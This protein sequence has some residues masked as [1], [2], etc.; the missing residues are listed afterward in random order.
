MIGPWILALGLVTPRSLQ[1]VAR[2][3]AEP[4]IVEVALGRLTTATMASFRVGSRVFVPVVEFFD[5]AEIKVIHSTAFA[6]EASIEPAGIPFRADRKVGRLELGRT[7]APL[8]DSNSLSANGMLYL[9]LETLAKTLGLQWNTSWADLT[10]TIVDPAALP[11]GQR[12]TREWRRRTQ[13]ARLPGELIPERILPDDRH[14]IDGLVLDYSAY[15]P[16]TG[17]FATG[18]Y[19]AALGLDVVGGSFT[20]SLESQNPGQ[21]GLRSEAAWAG[22]WRNRKWLTQLRLGD[23]LST[24]PR[25]RTVRGVSFGNSPYLRPNALGD[26]T[27]SGKLGPGWQVEAYRGGRLIG[28]DSVNALGR[29]TID[30]PIAYGENPVELIAYG[31]FGEVR[32]FNRTYRADPN[33]LPNGHLEYGAALGQCRTDRCQATANLDLRYGLSRHWTAQAG[34][35]QFWRP[36]STTNLFHPYF[37]LSGTI[38]N[39]FGVQFDAV[40]NAIVRG[41]L[42]YE[43][44]TSLIL[45]AEV[46]RFARGVAEPILTPEGRT[47]QITLT[48]IYFP[49]DR[50]SSLFIEGSVDRITTQSA[51]VTSGRIGVSYQY[52]QIQFVPSVR[53]QRDRTAGATIKQ[54]ILGLNAYLLPIPELGSLF[55]QATARVNIETSGRL[56]PATLT[57][58]ISRNLR[59][60]IRFELGGGWSQYQ[61]PM[62]SMQLAANLSTIRAV[63]SLSHNHGAITGNQF[64]QGSLLYDRRARRINFAAGPS[65]ERGGVVGR[66]FLDQN[67]N[68]QFDSGEQLLANVR[69][70]IGM[71]TR[72]SDDRGEYRLWN[73]AP[74]EP[75]VI[76][77]D[78]TTLQ[79]PLWAPSYAA[80]SIEPGPNRYRVVDIPISPGGVIEGRVVEARDSAGVAAVALTLTN[81]ATGVVRRIASFSDG[82]F[83]IMGVK[84]GEYRLGI[85]P[86]AAVRLGISVPPI[87]LTIVADPDGAIV[88]GVT[89]AISHVNR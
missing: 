56:K 34:L 25:P 71:E 32:R 58:F 62:I 46:T 75:A 64:V 73:I 72:V 20:A 29:Y 36:D 53:W 68:D 40:A 19:G 70:T 31:P 45:G 6:V 89:I 9:D 17:Q 50:Q 65:L 30:A 7:V 88:A 35:D 15:T 76:A 37:G 52:R 13:Q 55:G 44:R 60:D 79:S 41:S 66:V 67:G 48:G 5:L 23:G 84:P 18:A 33:R 63:T 21:R 1:P 86:A 49:A 39:A 77:V 61:G 28:F 83:Y 2:D 8:D 16:T 12:I 4:V 82:A 69:V 54:T 81:T 14:A 42:R 59:R 57:G 43:P 51:T 27:F 10:V 38:A 26:A 3:T 78:T 80:V 74:H 87:G 22:V 11:I 47:G 85:D 24:G